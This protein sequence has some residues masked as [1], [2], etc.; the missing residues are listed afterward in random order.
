M[1]T[2]AFVGIL[3]PKSYKVLF[4]IEHKSP[5]Q[6]HHNLQIVDK[7]LNKRSLSVYK[8]DVLDSKKTCIDNSYREY[9]YDIT[10]NILPGMVEDD[11]IP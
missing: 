8:T 4:D 6:K 10:S 9:T 1:S 7:S 2:S 11:S 3:K 5:E